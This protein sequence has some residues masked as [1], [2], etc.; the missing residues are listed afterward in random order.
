[1]S[2]KVL[3]A[4]QI[5][6]LRPPDVVYMGILPPMESCHSDQVLALA[7]D[8]HEALRAEVDRLTAELAEA[9]K[10]AREAIGKL[11]ETDT[12]DQGMRILLRIGGCNSETAES[13]TRITSVSLIDA[14]REG[15]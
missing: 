13:A 15:K 6:Q 5:R 1:M 2:D 3:T 4:T 14:A 9:R 8:S 10:D 11:A 7:C 12:Y